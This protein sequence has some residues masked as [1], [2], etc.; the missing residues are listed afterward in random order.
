MSDTLSGIECLFL[1]LRTHLSVG[2]GAIIPSTKDGVTNRKKTFNNDD[3][4]NIRVANGKSG[5]RR[6]K[7]Y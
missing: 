6:L 3:L 7:S 5:G 4:R 1:A 2:T